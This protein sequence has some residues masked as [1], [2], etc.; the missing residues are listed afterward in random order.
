[1]TGDRHKKEPFD[2]VWEDGWR[3]IERTWDDQPVTREEKRRAAVDPDF[4]PAGDRERVV[5]HLA[6]EE[7]ADALLRALSG[8]TRKKLKDWGLDRFEEGVW[9]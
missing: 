9:Y 4:R 6:D 5:A 8:V 2:A 1:M 3:V 7:T